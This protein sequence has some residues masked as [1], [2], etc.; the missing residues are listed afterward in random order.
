[1]SLG[2]AMIAVTSAAI[3]APASPT[4]GYSEKYTFI[5]AGKTIGTQTAEVTASDATSQTWTY[6]IRLN[7]P[8]NTQTLA[9]SEA[10]TLIVKADGAPVTFET[11][12]TTSGQTQAEKI[13]FN[14]NS[15][16]VTLSPAMPAIASSFPVTPGTYALTNNF[17]S[18]VSIISRATHTATIAPMMWRTLGTN[19]LREIAL[20]LT[21]TVAE[22]LYMRGVAVPCHVYDVA[23]L[24]SKIWLSDATGE[25]L[26]EADPAQQLVIVRE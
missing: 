8:I 6:K 16:N 12:A 3:A 1:M 23:P 19:S 20:T 13:V 17:L 14:G 2:L 24:N 25:L 7:V 22:T 11:K 21:P 10:G 9:M 15:V 5:M 4:V 18:G 26:K